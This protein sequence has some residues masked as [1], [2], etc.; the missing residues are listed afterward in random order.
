MILFL[1][2]ILGN[3]TY[4]LYFIVIVCYDINQW[5][6]RPWYENAWSFH[7]DPFS[8]SLQAHLVPKHSSPTLEF[9]R[10]MIDTCYIGDDENNIVVIV[11]RCL[12][13]L[14]VQY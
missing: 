5:S 14:Y 6:V 3:V 8:L 2:N 13:K 12:M 9:D 10:S 7:K 11:T 4:F 1:A